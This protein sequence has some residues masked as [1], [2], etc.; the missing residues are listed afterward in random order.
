[1]GLVRAI[2]FVLVYALLYNEIPGKGP[3]V[4]DL[5]IENI[6]KIGRTET[7]RICVTALLIG[8]YNRGRKKVKYIPKSACR[9]LLLSVRRWVTYYPADGDA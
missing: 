5:I 7:L 2:V 6:I 1:M 3:L 9:R 4:P 8:S